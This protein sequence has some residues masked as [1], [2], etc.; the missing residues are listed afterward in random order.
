M[1]P[2]SVLVGASVVIALGLSTC[3]VANAGEGRSAPTPP[4]NHRTITD[5]LNDIESK[6]DKLLPT[7]TTTAPPT[8][9]I[10]VP[11]PV[12]LPPIAQTLGVG[13]VPTPS[14]AKSLSG[15]GKHTITLSGVYDCDGKDVGWIEIK[16]SNVTVQNCKVTAN[17]QYGIY[18]E[19]TGNTIQNNDIKGLKPTGDGDMN[20]ITF[21]GNNTKI[22]FNTAIDF[23]AGSAGDSHTDFIQTWVSTSH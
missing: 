22:Q 7:T 2:S 5:Q 16:G 9:T 15:T 23:V 18:S 12:P 11:V 14:G 21:F 8:T 6:L 3:G 19:G 10:P 17:S 20:A 13:G 1:R 4:P